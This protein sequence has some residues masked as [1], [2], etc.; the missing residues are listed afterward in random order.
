MTIRYNAP[1]TL[2]FTFICA[3]VLLL[4]TV[5]PGLT[6]AWFSVPGRGGFDPQSFRD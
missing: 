2:T 6:K 4:N 3:V 1:T 5:F